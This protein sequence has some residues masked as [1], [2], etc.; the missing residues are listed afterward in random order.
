MKKSKIHPIEM[1]KIIE[2]YIKARSKL[3]LVKNLKGP[4]TKTSLFSLD[5]IKIKTKKES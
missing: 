5:Q 2:Q 1:K 3:E 4:P